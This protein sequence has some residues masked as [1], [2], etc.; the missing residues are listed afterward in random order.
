MIISVFKVITLSIFMDVANS[1]EL[2]C[3]VLNNPE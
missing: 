3:I 1:F 2:N